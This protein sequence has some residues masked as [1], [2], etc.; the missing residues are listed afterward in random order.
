[1]TKLLNEEISESTKPLILIYTDNKSLQNLFFKE[2]QKKLSLLFV[3]NTPPEQES[4]ETYHIKPTNIDLLPH[5]EEKLNYAIIVF[6][7]QKDKNF[8]EHLLKKIKDDNTKTIFLLPAQDYKNFIDVA[9]R[10]RQEVNIIPALYGEV[11]DDQT[12]ENETIKIIRIALARQRIRLD[13]NDLMPTFPISMHD[14]LVAI[15]HLLFSHKTHALYYIFYKNPQSLLSLV[16]HLARIEPEIEM[17]INHDKPIEKFEERASM[18]QYLHDKLNL[19]IHYLDNYLK[20]FDYAIENLKHKAKTFPSKPINKKPINKIKVPLKIPKFSPSIPLALFCSLFAF[21]SINI[22]FSIIGIIFLRSSIYAFEKSDFTSAKNNGSVAKTVLSVSMPTIEVMASTVSYV[23]FMESSYKTLSLITETAEMAVTSSDLIHN[24][25]EAKKGIAKNN[26]EAIIMN[27]QYLYHK[28]ARILLNQ[29]NRAIS[30]ILKPE[31]TKSINLISIAPEILGYS[32]EKEYLIL[33]MNNAELRPNGGFIGSVGRLILENGQIKDFTIEDVYDLDG[34]LTQHIEPHYI[35]RR[36]LQPH[37]YLRDSNFELDFQRSAS[38]SAMIYNLESKNTPDGVVAVDFTLIEKILEIIGPINLNS[39]DETITAE[40]S[41]EFLQETIDDNNF[42]GSTQKK[43]LLNELFVAIMLELEKKPERL[44]SIG[45]SIPQLLEEKHIL[46]AHQ[47]QNLQSL[48]S[49]LNFG[50]QIPLREGSSENTIYDTLGFNESNIG[51]NKVNRN[52]SRSINYEADLT[53]RLSRASISLRN[54]SE[55]DDYTAYIRLIAPRNSVL[56][57][58]LVNG[59][60]Q[61]TI[62]AVTDYRIFEN[63]NFSPADNVLEIDTVD[64]YSKTIFGTVINLKKNQI[65][66]IEFEYT[67]PSL[68]LND[69]KDSYDLYVIKQPGTYTTPSTFNI[70]FPAEF[71]ASVENATSYGKGVVK[72]ENNINTDLNYNVKFTKE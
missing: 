43:E 53:S 67:N 51:V 9:L 34:Q 55:T 45:L 22:I 41:M 7:E 32:S 26:L 58:V 37:L 72:L 56:R 23:P 3:S 17:E 60:E 19:K 33:F 29:D 21:V 71:V 16:H 20:G 15:K 39:Y 64:D 36:Y 52:I 38:T 48:F 4:D 69:G 50:G 2:F 14:L 63:D 65:L 6:S 62:P 1:M 42:P 11:I 27:I 66:S 8:I 61:E 49:A 59:E 46:I 5:L 13:G 47:D 24:L 31:I 54:E 44:A 70:K 30:S 18:D 28:G 68:F 12:S 57:K 10:I 40:N 25:D 35:I